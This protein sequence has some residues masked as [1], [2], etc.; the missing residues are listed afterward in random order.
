M[1]YLVIMLIV[2]F[3]MSVESVF[4]DTPRLSV[5]LREMQHSDS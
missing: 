4:I 1:K 5:T 3:L 2:A